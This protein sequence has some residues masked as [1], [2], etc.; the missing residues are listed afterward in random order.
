MD[1][2]SDQKLEEH[3]LLN[4]GTEKMPTIIMFG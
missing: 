4:F 3:T 2:I 1:L